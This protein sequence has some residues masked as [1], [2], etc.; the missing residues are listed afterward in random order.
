MHLVYSLGMAARDSTSKGVQSD[1]VTILGYSYFPLPSLYPSSGPI[2][3]LCLA[4]E[5][6]VAEW[7][8]MLT[9]APSEETGEEQAEK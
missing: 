2:M 1:H 7:R 8:K 9:S 6:A 3:A 4:R 5:D